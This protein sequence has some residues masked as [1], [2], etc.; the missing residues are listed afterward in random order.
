M[1]GR[2]ERK[3]RLLPVTPF[4]TAVPFWGQS[5]QSLSSWAPE[6]DCSPRRIEEEMRVA[7]GKIFFFLFAKTKLFVCTAGPVYYG[8]P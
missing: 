6:R 2:S 3:D 8:P 5:T 7:K 1:G 4:R